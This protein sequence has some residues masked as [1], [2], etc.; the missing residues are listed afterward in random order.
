M[1]SEDK[2]TIATQLLYDINVTLDESYSEPDREIFPFLQPYF[3]LE[4]DLPFHA[5]FLKALKQLEPTRRVSV[6]R[7]VEEALKRCGVQW[8]GL[9]RGL[10]VFD[11]CQKLAPESLSTNLLTQLLRLRPH[12]RSEQRE[13][14][15]DLLLRRWKNVGINPQIHP[16]IW[17]DVVNDASLDGLVDT[18]EYLIHGPLRVQPAALNCLS[19]ASQRVGSLARAGKLSADQIVQLPSGIQNLQLAVIP[20]AQGSWPQAQPDFVNSEHREQVERDELLAYLCGLGYDQGLG[21]A[22]EEARIATQTEDEF[23]STIV[24]L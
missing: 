11:L 21:D 14:W 19:L 20:Y 2:D 18:L 5:R 9:W 15:I 10:E 22:D 6:V 12:S 23:E 1:N 7:G 17:Y 13:I 16:D 3:S 8:L 4:R 24:S